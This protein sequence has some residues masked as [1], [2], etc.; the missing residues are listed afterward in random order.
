MYTLFLEGDL[1]PSSSLV[2]SPDTEIL[3]PSI[4]LLFVLA[5]HLTGCFVPSLT[6]GLGVV[7]PIFKFAQVVH[8]TYTHTSLTY[9][10][11]ERY[12]FFFS[13]INEFT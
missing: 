1:H 4:F 10:L 6:R 13:C 12:G 2:C 5:S 9:S 3:I 8:F 11:T 7:K